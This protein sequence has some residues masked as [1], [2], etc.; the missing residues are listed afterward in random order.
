MAPPTDGT[1]P[2]PQACM[3][4]PT[5]G[6][7][8]PPQACMAPPTDGARSKPKTTHP[9]DAPSGMDRPACG[10]LPKP[11]LRTSAR[12]ESEEGATQCERLS[13]ARQAL[14]Q[15]LVGQAEAPVAVVPPQRCGRM[16][17]DDP[18]AR[19]SPRRAQA[20]VEA[21]AREMFDLEEITPTSPKDAPAKLSKMPTGK[22][23]SSDKHTSAIKEHRERVFV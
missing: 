18:T 20:P 14:P 13:V 8:P 15:Q 10:S 7:L 23:L 16:E 6:A 17:Q 19:R 5:D 4:P 22:V 21:G 12:L 1:L 3:A 2:P 11:S 9:L